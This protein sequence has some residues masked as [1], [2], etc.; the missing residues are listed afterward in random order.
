MRE[1]VE[2][3]LADD[4]CEIGSQFVG[5]P[6]SHHAIS[7]INNLMRQRISALTAMG[8]LPPN[9]RVELICHEYRGNLSYNMRGT[10]DLPNCPRVN[11]I[12]TGSPAYPYR[13]FTVDGEFEVGACEE[14]PNA[15]GITMLS[16]DHLGLVRLHPLPVV[17][18][19]IDYMD[20]GECLLEINSAAALEQACDRLVGGYWIEADNQDRDAC[21]FCDGELKNI[22]ELVG[23][24]HLTF[25]VCDSC[26]RRPH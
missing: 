22:S 14:G 6:T 16:V 12:E 25:K 2:G 19:R 18:E 15:Y 1:Y 11:L 8:V 4:F 13:A 20:E 3:L 26:D 9:H 17:V 24:K 21:L 7:Q 5:T 23:N 10:Q